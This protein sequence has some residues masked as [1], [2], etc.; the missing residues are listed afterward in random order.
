VESDDMPQPL[1]RVRPGAGRMGGPQHI[2]MRPELA[3]LVMGV[4]SA[5]TYTE[6]SL[7][8]ILA[9][10]L[11]ADSSAGLAM[12]LSLS[13]GEAKRTTL[14]AAA[15]ANLTPE[16]LELFTLVMKAIKP[17]RERRNDFAHGMWTISDDLPDALL[18]DA[19]KAELLEFE[20]SLK[21][22]PREGIMGT[23]VYTRRDLQ[24]DLADGA[25]ATAAVHQLS[26]LINPKMA[27]L[28]AETLPQ[29]LA[30]PLLARVSRD[31]PQ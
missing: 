19:P 24:R 29:L 13:G 6:I 5:W 22:T 10:C 26:R 18:W 27:F 31:R 17:V 9:T 23:L 2:T 7:G 16:H 21:E 11:H 4:I 15:H 3:V 30:S 1:S 25:A 8:R 20:K 28:H 12:Y 14:E